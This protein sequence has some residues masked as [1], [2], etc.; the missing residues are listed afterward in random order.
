MQSWVNF[1]SM[2]LVAVVDDVYLHV[3]PF[4]QSGDTDRHMM[5]LGLDVNKRASVTATVAVKLLG[6]NYHC[7]AV[8]PCPNWLIA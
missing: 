4:V 5:R 7:Q 1:S 8:A 2:P 6:L 3:P